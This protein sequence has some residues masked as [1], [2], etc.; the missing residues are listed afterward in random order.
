MNIHEV[1]ITDDKYPVKLKNIYEPPKKLYVCGNVNILNNDGIAIIGCRNCS[2]YGAIVTRKIAF[3]LAKKK[4][5]IISGLARGIDTNAHI[6]TL[7]SNG[8][9]IAVL[10]SGLD[11]IY[12][13]E[14]IEVA[15]KIVNSGGAVI[16][17]YPLGTKPIPKNFPKRNRII[18]G[19]ADSIIVVEAKKKSGALI[20]VDFALEQ[21]KSVYAVPGDINRLT[22]IGTNELIKEGAIPFTCVEDI[23]N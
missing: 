6:G 7:N 12:P 4:F 19:L 1:N 2:R 8:T 13:H 20:T 10:G 14:N 21:G 18:S 16:T 3:L 17:E 22:S 23:L 9:T 11:N 15:K 5:N